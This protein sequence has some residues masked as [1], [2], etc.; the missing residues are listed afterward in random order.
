MK[1]KNVLKLSVL[2]ILLSIIFGIKPAYSQVYVSCGCDC[3]LGYSNTG[4]NHTI[5][6]QST[7]I[8]TLDGNPI[9]TNATNTVYIGAYFDSAGISR[10][11]GFHL[12]NGTQGGFSIWG[13]EAG[14]NNGFA[15]GEIVQW[16]LNVINIATGECSVYDAEPT[17]GAI[18]PNQGNFVVNGM[19][20]LESLAATSVLGI[21]TVAWLSPLDA[22][23]LS[24]EEVVSVSFRNDT[25]G[26]ISEDVI[27]TYTI[28]GG[29]PVSEIYS[30]GINSF[31][32][33]V[34]TFTQTADLSSVG[35]IYSVEFTI[36]L[37]DT[38]EP[39]TLNNTLSTTVQN[40]IPPSVSF[41]ISNTNTYPTFPNLCFYSN[42]AMPPVVLQ[43]TP[44]GGT[45]TGDGIQANFFFP[46]IAKS[47]CPTCTEFEITYNYFDPITECVGFY[48]MSIFLNTV[49]VAT[50]TN[51]DLDLCVF[52]TI[53]ITATPPGGTFSG[54]SAAYLNPT[55]GVF[56]PAIANPYNISYT[57]INST[58]GCGDTSN[59][60]VFTAHAL[61]VATIPNLHRAY[62][63]D[64]ADVTLTGSPAGGTFSS[65]TGAVIQNGVFKPS[66][67]SVSTHSIR[68]EYTNTYG[69]FDDFQINIRVF[70]GNPTLDYSG[71]N[72][73]YCLFGD[74]SLLTPSFTVAP[75][76]TSW[77]GA[78]SLGYF[79]PSTVGNKTVTLTGN[80][81][82]TYFTDTAVCNNMVSKNTIVYGL[83]NLN[84]ANT[85]NLTLSNIGSVETAQPDTVVLYGGPGFSYSWST[86]QTTPSITTTG[87]GVYYLTITN[88][89]TTC[90]NTDSIFVSG[91]DLKILELISPT[92]NCEL[93]NPCSIPVTVSVT[94]PG[95]YT[96][97]INDIIGFTGKIGN[98]LVQSQTIQLGVNTSLTSIAPGDT[99]LFTFNSQLPGCASLENVGD[100]NF[101]IVARFN[102]N[103]TISQLPD[104]NPNNDTLNTVVTNGGLPVVDLGD[105]ITS[106]SPDTISLD[107]G[108]GFVSYLWTSGA[109]GAIEQ[110]IDIPYFNGTQEYCVQVIDIY[111]CPA[112]DCITI[113]NSSDDWADSY[114]AVNVFPNPNS[115]RFTLD[116]KLQELSNLSV[117]II[118]INGRIV[119]QHQAKNVVQHIQDFDL[120][121]LAKGLYQIR[122]FNGSDYFTQKLIYQ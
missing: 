27:I 100:H 107:A 72:T 87:Y 55:T 6:V 66:Q 17:F 43:G 94:N 3:D 50:I 23:Y 68:Y 9:I 34:Y 4:I 96:F 63:S 89:N 79:I 19:S 41:N 47:I 101:R 7:A 102:H 103:Q 57:F 83:P 97:K 10:P 78:S 106:S 56:T 85:S 121:S 69:C 39:D 77:T 75:S 53:T 109:A 67:T 61:P 88:N 111:G 40:V 110:I 58:T 80:W 108:A 35:S 22:C 48:T 5:L 114:T 11:A 29:T 8:I 71:L 95:T 26:V 25:I 36:E 51:T 33:I 37:A 86:G 115:G 81:I 84:L 38:E 64:G 46:S 113:F 60:K 15:V 92:S 119:M 90:Q 98:N 70:N 54:A 122:I 31:D 30:G 16:K 20:A 65:P 28:N 99:V 120:S 104:V 62:C 93:I 2:T 118:D 1:M 73:T 82:N 52:E 14:L 12:W 74:S 45:F 44:A 32:T 18:L 59:I 13:T 117:D 49:P 76:S 24:D 42:P 116:I 21:E 105:N 112:S 91:T